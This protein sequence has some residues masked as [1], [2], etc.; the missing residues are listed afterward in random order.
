PISK[1]QGSSFLVNYRYSTVG[2]IQELGLV[3]V[4]G[5]PRF[6][7]AAFKLM[8]PTEKFGIFSF[9]GLGG[10]SK[11][12]FLDV[13]QS[14]W[15]TPGNNGMRG[16]IQEDFYKNAHLLNLGMNHTLSLSDNSYLK[17]TLLFSTEGI[18]DEIIESRFVRILDGNDQVLRDSMVSQGPNFNSQLEKRSYRGAMTYNHKLNARN[19]IQIG[20]KFA[21][22][23]YVINQSQ[24][25]PDGQ[26]RFNL[27]DMDENISTLRNFISWKHRLNENLTFVGGVHNMNVLFNNKSTIEPR[28][29]INWK[30]NDRSRFSLGYG[31]H[32]NME[33]VHSYFAQV[34]DP[35]GTI[36]QPN[37][38]LD[39]LKAHHIVLGYERRIGQNMR[40]KV[41][42]YYQDLYNL[43]VENNDTSYFATINEGLEFR[44][45]DLVNEGTGRNYGIELTLE[46]FFA[47]NYYFMINASLYRSL[48]T[49]LDG[50]ERSTQYD[51]EF[52]V[53]VLA[54]KEFVG[55][56]KKKN[57]TLGL[58]LKA[59]FG[60]G[61][62]IIPLLRDANGNLAVDPANN[63][64]FDYDRAYED[65]L[66]D[67]YT[68]ILSAS[69]KWNRPKT[70]HEVFVNLENITNV[71][72]KISEFYDEDEPG[73]IGYLAQ[74]G[75]FPN[76]MYRVYF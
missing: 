28:L 46:R 42:L 15:E 29:A 33:G 73:Q 71:K 38:D 26:S 41:E 13:D 20:T 48:Y 62:K 75:F 16:D 34:Q 8:L 47:K 11:L 60:G 36:R 59:F 45:V 61:R 21:L 32:S 44:Y 35:D 57:Q 69:Y 43:P 49:P 65:K 52:L 74:F 2:L 40:A 30:L 25:L 58:N 19:K 6:Q 31:L 63:R 14:L 76:L 22:F 72:G 37:L 51:G 50:R 67:L 55:L 10:L 18:D 24:L 70:T 5:T 64:F 17:T 9:F 12:D 27:V 68:I 54:G 39:L 53:N 7:D 23:D 4:N 3:D 1:K 56:G 66:Q